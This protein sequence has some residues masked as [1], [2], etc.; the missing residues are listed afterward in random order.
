[1]KR[2]MGLIVFLAVVAPVGAWAAKKKTPPTPNVQELYGLNWGV[3]VGIAVD[4][5]SR[6]RAK[7]ASLVNGVVRIDDDEDTRLGLILEGHLLCP[8]SLDSFKKFRSRDCGVDNPTGVSL[9]L[10]P[11]VA[12]R[13]GNEVLD[14]FGG[15][16]MFGLI[17]KKQN[18]T[19][20]FMN[21]GVGFL[22]ER[23][24]RVLG[25]GI[26]EGAP[27][28]GS[29]ETIRFQNKSVGSWLFLFSFRF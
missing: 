22:L 11:F 16:L 15:G 12:A 4:M 9:G 8:Y 29:E 5:K 27:L 2:A 25:N 23:N 21:F 3:G 14:A 28:P 26:K 18:Q 24:V 19:A 7:K 10:G 6:R 1:M 17:E 13:F 20:K